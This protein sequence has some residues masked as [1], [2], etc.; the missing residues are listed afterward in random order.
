MFIYW[1][2]PAVCLSFRPTFTTSP[3]CGS[4]GVPSAPEMPPHFIKKMSGRVEKPAASSL[5]VRGLLFAQQP[6]SA[7]SE[8]F[9]I[10]LLGWF[11]LWLGRCLQQG[12]PGGQEDEGGAV[13]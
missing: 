4:L 10:G 12:M 13:L 6:G 9:N 8:K 2:G 5:G 1:H 11:I 3:G 7:G